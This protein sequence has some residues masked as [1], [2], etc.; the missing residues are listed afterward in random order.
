MNRQPETYRPLSNLKLQGGK[1]ALLF[2]ILISFSATIASAQQDTTRTQVEQ[3][4]ERAIEE[5]DPEETDR[6]I[7]DLAEFLQEI[8]ANPVNIN[9]AGVDELLQVPG[10]NFRQARSIVTYREN[11][12]PFRTVDDL[13]NVPGIGRTTLNRVQPYVTAGTGR[14]L[15]RDLYLNPRYWTMNGRFEGFSRIQQVLEPQQ[16]YQR[17]DT[18]GGFTGS[19]VK[20]YQRFRYQSNYLSLNLTQDKDPGETLANPADFDFN[21]WHIAL[22]NNGRLQSLV[23]GDYSVAFG[24]GLLLWSGGAFGKGS[25]ATR[26]VSKNERGIR[27][28]T[29]AAEAS[30]FRGI[31]ATYG[32]R[33]QVTG[34][35]SNRKR[36]ATEVDEIYVRF[37][38]QSGF[39]RTL[40]ERERRNNLGQETYGGRIRAEIPI[41]FLGVS[42]FHNRFSRPVIRGTQPYQLHSFEGQKLTGYSA[43]Y[44][45]IAGPALLFGEAAFTDNGGY[46]F[47]SG[48][49]LDLGEQTTAVLA[50]RYYDSK[51]QSIFG[52]GFGE[53]S[54]TPRNEEGFYFGLRHSI[55]SKL[56]V[57]A[58]F[59]QFRFPTARFQTRQSTSGFDGL[60]LIEFS[61]FRELSLF[62]LVRFKVREQEYRSSDEFGRE[63]R[64]LGNSSRANARIQAEYWVLPTVRLR[65]RFDIVQI[66]R[67]LGEAGTGYLLFQDI[68]FYPHQRLRIDARITLFDTDGFDSRVYQ[69]ENDL[70][71]VLS[72]TMLFDRGQ[73]VYS[74][75]NYKASDRLEVWFKIATTVYENRNVISSG[76]SEIIGNRRSDIGLQARLRF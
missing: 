36:T 63:V 32:N 18:L 52:A 44:R 53:Q 51:L 47:I 4:I 29:S 43:D 38:T 73:R 76:N 71:Y 56:R 10:L 39:H 69:F 27:P 74:V 34:F 75:I 11:E 7:E 6:D 16:G 22:Q 65:T 15:G 13:L 57:N 40:S 54:G 59:D 67:A 3:D 30:G 60:G 72:N 46:G 8:A 9:R 48:S 24:Q 25:D 1:A 62:A 17:P 35:Y 31:A 20:Y 42:A 64:L 14:E 55:N 70:L 28:F 45:L 37:P 26:G 68:R 21:S 33:L 23:L 58:Y 12:M 66:S 2:L 50:Y 41:G 61:P 49:E 5:F 19:P